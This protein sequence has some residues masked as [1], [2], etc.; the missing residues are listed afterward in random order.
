MKRYGIP[1]GAAFGMLALIL[2]GKTALTGAAEAV[3]LCLWTLVPSLFPF[4]VLSI[5]LTGSLS[6]SLLPAG[7]LGGYPVGAQ[8]VALACKAGRLNRESAQRMI[9]YCN[10]A[11]PSFLFGII[12][13]L[14]SQW[15]VPWLLW[16]IHLIS[17]FILSAIL[18]FPIRTGTKESDTQSISLTFAVRKALSAMAGV[19]AWVILFRI[20]LAFLDRWLL[21]ILPDMLRL[22]IH[23]LLELS[24]GCLELAQVDQDGLRF[25]IAAL[26]LG[27][28]GCCVT[29]QTF[30]VADNVPM[31]L[32]FPGKVFQGCF[33]FLLAN[34]VQFLFLP[35]QRYLPY[36]AGLLG[37]FFI[38]LICLLIL[39]RDEKRCSNP[40]PV[41]V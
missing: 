31:N 14:F 34:M 25:S 32:Y 3:E 37:A 12:G 19:C 13:P 6:V 23:G 7:I 9:V 39:R 17:A 28:G 38:G 26:F 33:S 35:E 21:W 41:V 36:P 20:L 5:L 4:F 2:D 40:F 15:W 27:F 10:C 8:N 24:N 30:S 1:V 18:R 29:L 22:T 16:L 11:G